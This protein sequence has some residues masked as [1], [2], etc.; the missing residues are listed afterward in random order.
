MSA[1][2]SPRAKRSIL[3]LALLLVLGAC[4]PAGPEDPVGAGTAAETAWVGTITTEGNVTTVVNES[5]S[6][7]GGPARLVEELSIGVETGAEEHMFGDIAGLAAD[8]DRI[9]V[10]DSQLP[11]LRVYDMEGRHLRDLGGE[12]DG[13][14]EFRR[15]RYVAVADDGTILVM[16]RGNRR[17]NLYGPESGATTTWS[18][19]RWVQCCIRP[20]VLADDGTV[21][22]EIGELNEE[23]RDF[24]PGMQRHGP[25]GPI[26]EPLMVPQFEYERWTYKRNGREIESVQYA[27]GVVWAIASPGRLVAGS[28]DRYRFEIHDSVGAVTVVERRAEPVALI[29]EE[30]AFARRMMERRGR[31]ESGRETD[32]EWDG[33]LPTHKPMFSFFL[34]TKDGRLWVLRE[35]VAEPVPDCDPSTVEGPRVGPME[36]L[37]GRCFTL[38]MHIDVFDTDGRY[39]GEI[40]LTGVPTPSIVDTFVRGD[41][42]VTVGQDEL[43]TITVRRYRLEIPGGGSR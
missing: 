6:V 33:R 4:T 22:V 41:M 14:G 15:P 31:G 13:P 3:S 32:F 24:D 17:M 16:A 36:P 42:V 37:P 23:R 40:D 8:E 10:L 43:G 35:G 27:P 30:I 9:F 29:D 12:G 21:W 38:P 39:L 25:D 2:R 18:L 11:A 7:W 28:S 1:R 26:G 5:G 19:S 34:P 20:F